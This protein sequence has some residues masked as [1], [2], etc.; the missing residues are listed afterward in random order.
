LG[1][2]ASVLDRVQGETLSALHAAGTAAG[3][4]AD[5]AAQQAR[6][7]R[8]A[9][10][11]GDAGDD[12]LRVEYVKKEQASRDLVSHAA[13][14]V[15]VQKSAVD[16][17]VADRDRAAQAAID[18][19]HQIT[20]GDGLNDSWW[21][22]WGVKIT[23]WVAKIAE[24]IATIA[25]I[26]ALLVCWIP[27]VGQALAGVLLIVAAVA[28]IVAALANIVLAAT[29]EK[30][31]GEAALS[32]VFAALGCIGL[33]SLRGALG[34]LKGAFGAWRAAGGLAG[35]GGLRGVALASV[36]NFALTMKNLSIFAKL[37]MQPSVPAMIGDRKVTQEVY[38][39]LRA[40]T[41]GQAMR[42]VVNLGHNAGV[43]IPDFALP[44]KTILGRLQADHIVPMDTIVRMEGFDLL[45][46][47]QQLAV[48]NFPE[49]F[50][51]LSASANASKGA[52]SYGGWTMH[53]SSGL[54]VNPLFR[55]QMMHL[56][57]A[58]E[59][60]LQALINSYL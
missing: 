3:A 52:L 35:L 53:V 2:Y 10:E 17:A 25:G 23:E 44:G 5:A 34:G 13:G 24:A 56:G 47:P 28:G 12:D 40:G 50:A 33:G 37:K 38:D 14:A 48:L 21:D 57:N 20:S 19:I 45:T 22:D 58:L 36:K 54:S 15:G 9:Q 51:G 59:G 39:M 1:A 16:G 27:V 8:L 41:P 43:V 55:T 18:S 26:L 30:S 42:D 60:R 31:W 7:H 29:G 32:V 46:K 11:A 6:F 4:G 49:N